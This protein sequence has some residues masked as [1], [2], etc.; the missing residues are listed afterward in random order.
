MLAEARQASVNEPTLNLYVKKLAAWPIDSV[1]HVCTKMA[2]T[3]R[4]EGETAFPALGDLFEAL[5]IHRA[6]WAQETADQR[7]REYREQVFWNFVDDQ[8][9]TLGMSEQEVL[10]T[11]MVA[12]YRGRKARSPEL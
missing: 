3:Q 6:K 11:I 4:R 8:K 10:D 1:E 2:T 9:K 5:K 12:G 7:E